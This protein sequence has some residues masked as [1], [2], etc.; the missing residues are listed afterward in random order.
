MERSFIPEINHIPSFD[1][2][3]TNNQEN[4]EEVNHHSRPE[5]SE[6]R[7][8][9]SIYTSGTLN[10]FKGSAFY[11]PQI[12]NEK[13]GDQYAF[14]QQ[15]LGNV[16]FQRQDFVKNQELNQ[17][18]RE[19]PSHRNRNQGDNFFLTLHSIIYRM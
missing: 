19:I 11:F 5:S 13:L 14:Q 4:L 1:R 15:D 8:D 3:Q 6:I 18:N 16:P 12:R 7:I 17:Y 9:P 10:H 2:I